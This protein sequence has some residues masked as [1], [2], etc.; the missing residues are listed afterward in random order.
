MVIRSARPVCV[1][2]LRRISNSLNKP[3][4]GR[5]KTR[6]AFSRSTWAAA[7][8]LLWPWLGAGSKRDGESSVHT[9]RCWSLRIGGEE[10]EGTHEG[11]RG[12]LAA[13]KQIQMW[14]GARN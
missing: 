14:N 9:R 2:Y 10:S 13:K 7:L 1:R 4:L 6:S 3:A 5:S 12:P 8:Q 11:V